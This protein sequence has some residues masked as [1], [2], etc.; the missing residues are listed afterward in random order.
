MRPPVL[1]TAQGFSGMVKV[2]DTIMSEIQKVLAICRMTSQC[3]PVVR[4]AAAQA[5][6]FGARLYVLH[7]I[8]DP[9]GIEGWSL[10]LPTLADDYRRLLIRT[11]KE[12][13][14]RLA[15]VEQEGIAV[16]ELIR[17]GKPVREILNVIS[18]EGIDLLV[19]PAHGESRL[20]HFLFGGDNDELV[21]A[22][23][24]AIMLVKREPKA[25]EDERLKRRY[26]PALAVWKE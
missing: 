19:L 10:P 8:Y 12:L 16:T 24:C 11:R 22:M 2:E 3:G 18:E 25:P 14:A 20:E 4:A 15:E 26:D 7:V 13:D 21:R 6:S 5:R 9:F 17:E 23:P 1:L